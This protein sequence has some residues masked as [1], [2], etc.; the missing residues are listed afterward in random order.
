MNTRSTE[1]SAE[2]VAA[3]VAEAESL[4]RQGRM[5]EAG[6]MWE[7]VIGMDPAHATALTQLGG[8]ALAA[9]ELEQAQH[10]LERA[11]AAAPRLA[12]A[13][14]H[15]SR[16]HTQRGDR[17][18]A[19]AA[20]DAAIA[21]DP[22]AWGPQLEK[23]RLLEAGG[24]HRAAALHWGNMLTY[25]PEALQRQANV[26]AVVRQA[27]VAVQR[28]RDEL[29][30]YLED[31]LAPLIKGHD[32]REVE[33]IRHSLDILAG[34]R[35][36]ITAKPLTLPIP[37]LPAIPIFHREDFDWAPEVESAFPDILEELHNVLGDQ[38]GFEPYVQTPE[39][40]PKG[41][42]AALDRSTDW[43]AYFLWKHG[44]RIDAQADACPRTEAAIARAPQIRVPGR[45]PV[46]FFSALR[47]GVHIP[48]H[49]GATNAR[50]TVHLPLII[51]PSDCG[52]RVGEEVHIWEPGRLV[53][54]DDTIRHEAWNFSDRLRVVLIF[55][56]WHPMLTPLER[57]LVVAMTQGLMGFYG[58]DADLGEL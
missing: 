22:T 45:A 14:A 54:F 28:T 16:V 52:L 33:R 50:L 2:L 55:D 57:E 25:M 30:A 18:A 39:G 56:V 5:R 21:A 58:D 3:L 19:L 51:P 31:N 4:T 8:L 27:Q 15:L 43:G 35:T 41:Q 47:P 44:R 38:S 23:A 32:A 13:H 49:N 12:M 36:F 20:I 34:R 46:I 1:R 48:P 40:Q 24:D 11:I 7:R 10:Y 42:F 9:G 6:A 17:A 53:M 26:Q 29:G 37:R